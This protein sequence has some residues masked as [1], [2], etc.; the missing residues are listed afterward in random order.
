MNDR[1]FLETVFDNVESMLQEACV[2][3]LRLSGL[4]KSIEKR[5]K[6]KDCSCLLCKDT[7]YYTQSGKPEDLIECIC[8]VGKRLAAK[9]SAENIETAEKQNDDK[10]S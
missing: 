10:S 9:K 1:Q 3:Q 8:S 7:G 6:E 4:K 5:L 2:L